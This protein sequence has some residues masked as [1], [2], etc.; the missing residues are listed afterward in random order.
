[1]R[2]GLQCAEHVFHHGADVAADR[3][4]G[5]EHAA[6]PGGVAV[7]LRD[8]LAAQQ[9]GVP[10]VAGAFVEAGTEH[11]Q[12]V[13]VIDQIA[14]G[15][16]VGG[17]AEAAERQRRAF[18]HH[19]LGLEAGGDRDVEASRTGRRRASRAPAWMQPYPATMAGWR[20][21]RISA[22][23]SVVGV[24]WRC[25]DA[26]KVDLLQHAVVDRFLLHVV[27][28]RQQH[29]PGIAPEQRLRRLVQHLAEIVGAFDQ[30]VIA[31]DAGEQCALVDGAALARAFLQAAA[32]EDVGRGLAGDGQHRQ[33]FGIGIGDAGDEV[34]RAGSGGG[35]AGRRSQRYPR[36]TARHEGCALFVLHQHALQFRIVEAVVDRQH[37]RTGHAENGVD[38][39]A[40]QVP[41][42]QFADGNIHGLVMDIVWSRS[43]G[44]LCASGRPRFEH[45]SSCGKTSA[46]A[47]DRVRSRR[48]GIERNAC[49]P[50]TPLPCDFRRFP[51]KLNR[52][53][54][55]S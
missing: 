12:Q 51:G 48:N 22:A 46:G 32:A 49:P 7:D 4:V 11:D 36:I 50:R 40:L 26:R 27:G 14:V 37:M 6:E 30:L 5:L 20:A 19:A 55:R 2:V 8:F 41:D 47:W 23:S 18:G 9:F 45:K 25:A 28:N 10:Q 35:D 34:G 33:P 53:H 43:A 21:A 42:N 44:A 17:D 38:A 39:Q 54:A 15:C 24:A 1:M 13:G 16:A 52:K 29:R 31:R 3:H